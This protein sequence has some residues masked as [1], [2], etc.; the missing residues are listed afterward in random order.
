[1][2]PMMR[3]MAE[4]SPA[5]M[6]AESDAGGAGGTKSYSETNVQVEGVDEADIVKTDGTYLY[7]VQGQSV[8]IVQAHPAADM[9]IMSTVDFTEE[10]FT[11]Q[12]LYI[13]G[14]RLIVIGNR[15]S[16]GG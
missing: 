4:S 9:K 12:D 3:G 14:D 16:Y 7:I 6:A 5:P 2:M 15:F 13:D 1:M 8:R 10:F 11:P